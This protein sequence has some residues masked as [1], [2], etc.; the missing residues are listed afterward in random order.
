MK[1]H[2]S[3][4]FM[5]EYQNIYLD[6]GVKVSVSSFQGSPGSLQEHYLMLTLP[7][8]EG[9]FKSRIDALTESFDRVR[10]CNE[11]LKDI[12]PVFCRW[13][14]SDIANQEDKIPENTFNC[15]QSI[16]GQPP[17]DA[18]KVALWIY[19]VSRV[20]SE[21]ISDNFYGF[22]HSAYRHFWLGDC[23]KSQESPR[24][25]TEDSLVRYDTLL[26]KQGC[27][28][29]DNCLR[30]WFFV[31]DVDINYKDMV[32][33]RNN[34]FGKFGLTPHTHFIASTGIGGEKSNP[35][36]RVIFNA[37]AV[38]GLNSNQIKYLNARTHL[39]P[40]IEYGVAFERATS[41]DYGD[42]R[43]VIISGTASIDKKGEILHKGDV[44][45]QAQR[46]IENVGAL[47]AEAESRWEDVTHIIVYLRDFS[48]YGIIR[49]IMLQQ[50]PDIPMVMV[51]APVCRPG[52]LIEMECGAI[53][54]GKWEEFA[55]F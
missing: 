3:S 38:K 55:P 33:G 21:K 47:L 9:N 7:D 31:R 54:S 14:L 41:V 30:T 8:F 24:I 44:A 27:S 6:N 34:A 49:P 12:S 5:I 53:K 18:S 51:Q 1:T 19:C 28:I 29:F 4:G 25:A 15:A 50:F 17:L 35:Y 16:I 10:C 13:F 48:D 11:S 22:Q 20:E 36:E 43:H 46:M 2:S 40:T 45:K 37:F 26:K 42:R 23:L 52:W 32:E 39:N